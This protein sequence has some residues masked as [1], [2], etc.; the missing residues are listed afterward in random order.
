ML[1]ADDLTLASH[2]GLSAVSVPSAEESR[3]DS[4]AFL[5]WLRGWARSWFRE[6]S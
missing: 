6:Q 3:P 5:F 4:S 1:A 2:V